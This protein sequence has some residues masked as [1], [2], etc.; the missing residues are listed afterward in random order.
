MYFIDKTDLIKVSFYSREKLAG[1]LLF[2]HG[3]ID[4]MLLSGLS[5]ISIRHFNCTL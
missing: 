4:V 1:T 3:Q 2:L 5:L